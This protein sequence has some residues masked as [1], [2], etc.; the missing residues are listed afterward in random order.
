MPFRS[1]S[2]RKLFY[3]KMHRGELSPETVKK[4]EEHT[5]KDT[6]LPEKV[7][8]VRLSTAQQFHKKVLKNKAKPVSKPK[9]V[10]MSSSESPHIQELRKKYPLSNFM[11]DTEKV[12][13]M[14]SFWSGFAKKAA[15]NFASSGS[16]VGSPEKLLKWNVQGGVDPR[17]PEDMQK[18]QASVLRTLPTDVEGAA[19]GTC[20][21]FRSL[22][23][24]LGHGFCTNPN[25]QMDVTEHMH[26]MHWE[27]PGSYDPVDAAA[28]E[29]QAQDVQNS[30]MG[31]Q[32]MPPEQMGQE[33]QP[34]QDPQAAQGQPG[35]AMGMQD[36]LALQG[37][38]LSGSAGSQSTGMQQ[39]EAPT[40]GSTGQAFKP[41]PVERQTGFPMG[42]QTSQ[43]PMVEQ[44]VNDIQGDGAVAGPTGQEGGSPEQATPKKPKKKSSGSSKGGKEEK[45]DS[46]GNTINIHVGKGSEKTASFDYWRGIVD[47][48]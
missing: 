31:Q 20:V 32:G 42:Q 21:H 36:Q 44:A 47:G 3:A 22:S 10:G 18:A 28:E 5:P 4:W 19:C 25:V 37:Q 35:K 24:K 48:Y 11:N 43:N 9:F 26:C 29:A 2:Q 23:D 14:N 1:Q 30:Q 15:E 17:T 8:G 7:A 12:A 34:P 41:S 6:K 33:A 27:H 38:P 46:K 39:E 16:P 40:D 45:K 13:S